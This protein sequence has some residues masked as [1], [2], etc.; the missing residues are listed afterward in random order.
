MRCFLL[1]VWCF[2]SVTSCN[3]HQAREVGD[4]A[5]GIAP[6][7]DQVVSIV[8]PRLALVE[9]AVEGFQDGLDE[10]QRRREEDGI[11]LDSNLTFSDWLI[12]GV[13]AVTTAFGGVG[14]MGQRRNRSRK[15]FKD[16]ILTELRA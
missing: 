15:Q 10:V 6:I 9:G 1:V 14:I 8:D 13:T 11:E 2:L 16:E 3:L 4:T 5:D 12:V 7:V